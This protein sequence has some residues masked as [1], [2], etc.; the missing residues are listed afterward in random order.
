MFVFNRVYSFLFLFFFLMCYTCS[1]SCSCSSSLFFIFFSL[2]SL[3]F[4]I[5][6]H[7]S[8]C[9]SGSVTA[10]RRLIHSSTV[11]VH[12][13]S[14][15]RSPN[16]CAVA[17]NVDDQCR[18]CRN[19]P[20]RCVA[21]TVASEPFYAASDFRSQRPATETTLMTAIIPNSVFGK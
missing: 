2:L 11:C 18:P 4:R 8:W 12:A 13:T 5:F 14:A 9:S 21:T 19:T 1:N 10:T 16:C 20:W 6:I 7:V 17:A 3:F 15:T